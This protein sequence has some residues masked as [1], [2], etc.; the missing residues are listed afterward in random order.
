MVPAVLQSLVEEN[1]NNPSSSDQ[2]KAFLSQ[3]NENI[4]TETQQ[5]SQIKNKLQAVKLFD[6]MLRSY[7]SSINWAQ[8]E[9]N[10]E[11]GFAYAK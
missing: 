4:E 8:W 3:R 9:N 11:F 2:M 10:R 7:I 5:I 6:G 1:Q